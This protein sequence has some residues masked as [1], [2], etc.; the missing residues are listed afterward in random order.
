MMAV[1]YWG[2][3]HGDEVSKAAKKDRYNGHGEPTAGRRAWAYLGGPLHGAIAGKEGRKLRAAGSG[4]VGNYGGQAIGQLAG[5]ALTRGRGGNAGGALGAI[6]GSQVALEHNQRKGHLKRQYQ[7][8]K[9][10]KAFP[11][12]RPAGIKNGLKQAG[13]SSRNTPQAGLSM[14]QKL[15]KPT[16]VPKPPVQ[17]ARVTQAQNQMG[18]RGTR[19]LRRSA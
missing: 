19:G 2:V 15:P 10:V 18:A 5:A 4:F 8:G 17:A 12:F 11:G 9:I 14:I 6:G 16:T 7:N 1:S 3:D 13:Q